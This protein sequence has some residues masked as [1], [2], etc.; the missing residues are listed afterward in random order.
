MVTEKQLKELKIFDWRDIKATTDTIILGNGFSLNFCSNLNYQSLFNYSK[1]RLSEESLK[2][3]KQFNTENFEVVLEKLQIYKDVSRV[4]DFSDSDIDTVINEVKSVFITTIHELHPQS[5]SINFS[6]IKSIGNQLSKFSNVFTTNYDLFIY[7]VILQSDIDF[8][9]NFYKG[10]D[11]KGYED[12]LIFEK[13]DTQKKNHLYYLH[14]SLILF[15]DLWDTLKI[16]TSNG[17]KLLEVISGRIKDDI[18]LLYISEGDSRMKKKKIDSNLYLKYCFSELENNTN[19]EIVV[20][21]NSLSYQDNHIVELLDDNFERV[22]VSIKNFEH[23]TKI[24]LRSIVGQIQSRFKK[25][26]VVFYDS[27]TLFDFKKVLTGLI[28]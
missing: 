2:L 12:F 8:S 13:P 6:L 1:S 11:R 4:F 5:D 9:D 18:P 21:G 22:F 10:Y 23:S 28:R 19:S 15:E 20:Y 14:G 26:E 3:F 17:K 7:Y 25:T 27:D 16:R 24:Y